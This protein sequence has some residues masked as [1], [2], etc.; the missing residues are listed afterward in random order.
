MLINF[1]FIASWCA[2]TALVAYWAAPASAQNL[3]LNPSFEN[4]L[5]DWTV[6]SGSPYVAPAVDIA[7]PHT[8]SSALEMCCGTVD[9]G[10]TSGSGFAGAFQKV[11]NIIPGTQYTFSVWAKA[12]DSNYLTDGTDG[13]GREDVGVKFEWHSD[14]SG[15]NSSLET[16]EFGFITGA[17]GPGVLQ[18]PVLSDTYQQYSFQATAPAGAF[19][20]RPVFAARHINEAVFF[21]DISL[22]QLL[23][24][25]TPNFTVVVD[26][27]TGNISLE[28][29]GTADGSIK[30]VRITSASG[31]LDPISWTSIAGNYDLSGNGSVDSD[32]NWTR[33]TQTNAEFRETGNDASDGGLIAVG[34]GNS[35]D[36][37]NNAW[38]QSLTEDLAVEI[39]YANGSAFRP[40]QTN[41]ATVTYLGGPGGGGAFDR[42]D[43]DFDGD[44]D[45][46]DWPLIRDQL[47]ANISTTSE[48]LAYQAG[49]LNGDFKADL[50][51]FN[52]F[53]TDFDA[54]NG[55]GAFQ[56]MIASVPEPSSLVM[57]AFGVLGLSL[58]RRRKA[59]GFG[60]AACLLAVAITAGVMA[61]SAS[62]AA[63]AVN[64]TTFTVDDYPLAEGG[65]FNRFNLPTYTTTSSTAVLDVSSNPHVF[66]GTQ[67][68]LNKRI[69]G[70]INAGADDD[71]VGLALGYTAGDTANPDTSLG[72]GGADFL[73][74]DWKKNDSTQDILDE[75]DLIGP[76]TSQF[77]H[78]LTAAQA[79]QKGVALSRV[80]GT[81]TGDELWG[82][83]DLG[84]NDFTGFFGGLNQLQRG[85]ASG[86]TGYANNQDYV[87]DISYTSSKITVKINGTEEINISGS[88]P[89]GVLGLYSMDQNPANGAPTY[90]DFKISNLDEVLTAT[91]NTLS[92]SVTL[93]NSTSDPISLDGYVL[94]SPAGSLDFSSWSSFQ[95]QNQA[96]FAAGNGTGNGWEEG[97]SSSDAVLVEANLATSSTL[98]AGASISLGAAFDAGS[99]QDLVFNYS[100]GNGLISTG[101]INYVSSVEN[102]DF[103]GDGDKD[104]SDFLTWQRGFG[105]GSTLA[106]GDANA[107]GNVNGAD[108]AIW[109]AQYGS[110]ALQAVQSVPEPSSA[111]LLILASCGFGVS[112]SHRKS[113]RE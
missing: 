84:D 72:S 32:D 11:L 102:A 27:S 41:A 55:V 80:T 95:D 59:S 73:L 88:F 15:A 1:K 69:T 107:S 9:P 18:N 3:I 52:V 91:I 70:T 42:S 46:A 12:E 111:L 76:P 65:T 85:A 50:G 49:D 63:Q 53:K 24:P 47:Y 44:I 98:G 14:P 108:L 96:G 40:G 90:S 82:H 17:T 8:G 87:F 79:A 37:G 21:D 100:E 83:V 48:A 10:G 23:P 101:L 45:A 30:E 57:L 104:G 19:H 74:L 56:A 109:S 13:N 60:K 78:D 86:S 75:E 58:S 43:L 94:E 2:L 7:F 64:F 67:S 31:A 34:S 38:I 77:F 16:V 81:P 61:P 68:I 106:T 25:D 54:A 92:G 62:F 71:F 4:G 93:T 33:Q 26:R 35:V 28:N 110:G 20:F 105:S 103:N 39:I 99:A 29:N 6:F 89:D 5:D 66:Y 22:T 113:R 97:G 112:R 51:D 36:L